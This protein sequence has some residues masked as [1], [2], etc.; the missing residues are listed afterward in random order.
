MPDDQT[1]A[2]ILTLCDLMRNHNANINE[3]IASY[4]HA[5]NTVS[6]YRRSEHLPEIGRY[7]SADK[8]R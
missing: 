7:P 3:A 6:E 1:L 4:N 2:A 8:T 5:T